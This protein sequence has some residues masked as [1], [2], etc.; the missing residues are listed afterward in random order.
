MAIGTIHDF[1]T[2]LKSRGLSEHS[3]Q[4]FTLDIRQF[5]EFAGDRDISS[6][7]I[8]DWFSHLHEKGLTN[9]T[10]SRKRTALSI[11]SKWLGQSWELPKIKPEKR[12]PDALSEVEAKAV[13]EAA[14]Q[15]RHANRNRLMVEL[16]LRCGLRASELLSLK[17]E[18][19]QEDGGILYIHVVLGKGKK[20]RRIPV[21]YKPL[22]QAIKKYTKG[23][24]PSDI[25]FPMID[26]NLRKLV[27]DIGRKAGLSKRL[28]PHMLR[29][30]AAT[31][32][33][34][35]GANIESVRR[36]L[37]HES[38]ATTQKYLALTD[39]DVAK[40]LARATW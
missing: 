1:E 7:L 35:K 28:H 36:T 32:Y 34:R 10:L 37:G 39:E 27:A 18:D 31:L 9:K 20:D 13:L 15:T 5:L 3:I 38:L 11:Y 16:M 2:H 4:A 26:R 24:L 22:Q 21:T 23:M 33:L 12:L 6:S 17:A 14:G 30:T 19:F 40:D 29:H 8:S 25:L